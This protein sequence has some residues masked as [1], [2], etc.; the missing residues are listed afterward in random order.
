[1]ESQSTNEL[2]LSLW[3]YLSPS[4]VKRINLIGI[5]ISCL[6]TYFKHN[7]GSSFCKF[8][9]IN[10]IKLY[11]LNYDTFHHL[12][13]QLSSIYIDQRSYTVCNFSDK[14]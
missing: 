11:E 5:S 14:K 10:T 12:Q 13:N 4:S 8:T 1:M 7:S 9:Y 6:I 3:Y 2:E